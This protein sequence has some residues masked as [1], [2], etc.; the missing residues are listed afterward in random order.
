[1]TMRQWILGLAALVFVSG[2]AGAAD[3]N[4]PTAFIKDLGD[5]AIHILQTEPE[6]SGRKAAFSKIFNEDFDAPAIGR[7][8]LG[9]YWRI[10]TPDQQKQYLDVFTQYVVALY[11]TRF[12]TYSGEQFKVVNSRQN[13]P[14][15]AT[16][17][18]QILQGG[19]A[20]PIAVGWQVA[21]EGTAFKITD[22]TVD[23][24]SLAVT[25]RDEFGS[26][27]ETHGG[28]VQ[29][30]IDLLRQKAQES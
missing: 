27:I 9:R 13:D 15:T 30:L 21:R 2:T 25:K 17:N 10:A 28:D 24:L 11:A 4:D 22:V 6:A 5:K 16:V 8:V 12:A 7:F 19:G 23:N 29:A 20:P 26:V 14:A 1:M 18:S 3:S